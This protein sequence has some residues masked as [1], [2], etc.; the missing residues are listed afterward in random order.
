MLER[1]HRFLT[2]EKCDENLFVN[3]IPNSPLCNIFILLLSTDQSVNRF[4]HGFGFVNINSFSKHAID[5][6]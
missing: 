1:T 5:E 3:K 6:N 2:G 4:N